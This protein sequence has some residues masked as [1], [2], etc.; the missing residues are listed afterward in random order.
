VLCGRSRSVSC[1]YR[2]LEASDGSR[3]SRGTC[4]MKREKPIGNNGDGHNFAVVCQTFN[5]A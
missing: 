3:G 4:G 1:L 2:K 5:D